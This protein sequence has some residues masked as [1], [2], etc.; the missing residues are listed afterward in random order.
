MF[1]IRR[2]NLIVR[3]EKMLDNLTQQMTRVAMFANVKLVYP[4]N[5]SFE[6]LHQADPKF[7]RRGIV[8]AW[9]DE[10]TEAQHT[11]FWRYHA[12]AM[13]VAGYEK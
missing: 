11:A 13:E 2:A 8:G 10:M 6:T 5:M 7:Y 9:K 1:Y 12:E 3:Y 4:I